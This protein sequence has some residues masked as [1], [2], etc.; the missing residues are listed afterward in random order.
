[1]GKFDYTQH[2]LGVSMVKSQSNPFS[3]VLKKE[4]MFICDIVRSCK[5]FLSLFNE[6][7]LFRGTF[8]D[9]YIVDYKSGA[10][11][12]EK[13]EQ[14]EFYQLFLAVY[15]DEISLV[16]P[17]GSARH[18]NKF[19]QVY[20]QLLNIPKELRSKLDSIFL[21]AS[22]DTN[23][24]TKYS[25]NR[26]MKPI[27]SSLKLSQNPFEHEGYSKPLKVTVLN[28]IGDSPGSNFFAGNFC[29]TIP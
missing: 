9:N 15:A 23:H 5:I 22:I 19:W 27:I 2:S 26:C 20:G 28:F 12:K 14:G 13:Q 10:V 11:F 7:T 29:I 6:E 21:I 17:L 25:L 4:I 16:N 1:M 3:Y 24:I 18:T 8:D